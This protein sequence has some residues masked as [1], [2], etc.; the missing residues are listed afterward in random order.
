[1]TRRRK[2]AYSAL[3]F[4]AGLGS[5]EGILRLV[6]FGAG[7]DWAGLGSAF[8]QGVS[9]FSTHRADGEKR[10]IRRNVSPDEAHLFPHNEF[11]VPKPEGM[12]R[13]VCLGASS[14]YGDPAFPN[15]AW[16]SW[17]ERALKMAEPERRFEVINCGKEGLD[18]RGVRA[19]AEMATESWEPDAL[20][21][22]AGHNE[23]LFPQWA[24]SRPRAGGV[25]RWAT[26]LYD[27][28]TSLR[29]R[30]LVQPPSRLWGS[31][32]AWRDH[33]ARL[34]RGERAYS[35]AQRAFV[36]RAFE[37]NLRAIVRLVRRRGAALVLCVPPSA[38]QKGHPPLRSVAPPAAVA[39]TE[40]RRR[41][42]EGARAAGQGRHEDAARSYQ[43]ALAACP[44]HALTLYRLG[45]SYETL[46]KIDDARRP[47]E[48]AIERENPPMRAGPSINE[49][50]RRVAAAEGAPLVDLPAALRSRCA[51]GLI[52]GT[53]MADDTHPNLLGHQIVAFEV[54]KALRRALPDLARDGAGPWRP[55][56]PVDL[57]AEFGYTDAMRA[58]AHERAGERYMKLAL[59]SEPG[60]RLPLAERELAKA[61]A[62][63]PKRMRAI[64]SLAFTRLAAGDAAGTEVALARATALDP[65]VLTKAP[66]LARVLRAGGAEVAERRAIFPDRP[67][68]TVA[69]R[70]ELLRLVLGPS[71]PRQ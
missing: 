62:L 40:W 21:V 70:D 37:R 23:F 8:P 22:Y 28:S 12:I 29:L 20:V 61:S 41:F 58:Y 71:S 50:I 51:S 9:P 65:D 53:V 26:T 17:L 18:S 15:V 42:A 44:G 36:L 52:D 68:D 45:Q 14:V 69:V 3:V 64:V 47:Y 13:L 25:T 30:R 66:H 7:P 1:M 35:D 60:S 4:L 55:G 5:A 57:E 63:D 10:L 31:D 6:G 2:A 16:P 48:Q 56:D 67:I 38:S 11:V 27:A 19:F 59:L 49:I 39:A 24:Y 54:L 46:G 43:A 32:A 33:I 34:Q